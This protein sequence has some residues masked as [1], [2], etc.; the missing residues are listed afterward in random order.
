MA[1][2]ADE[3]NRELRSILDA[4]ASP[5]G[6][7]PEAYRDAL[8]APRF[9]PGIPGLPS[10][11][12]LRHADETL[13]WIEQNPENPR[14]PEILRDLS[15]EAGLQPPANRAPNP[16]ENAGSNP[17]LPAAPVIE[18][19]PEPSLALTER[20]KALLILIERRKAQ[21]ALI[22]VAPISAAPKPSPRVTSS[23][24]S[25]W[26]VSP[27]EPNQQGVPAVITALHALYD[28]G[29]PGKEHRETVL[30]AVNGWLENHGSR[31]IKIAT[32]YRALHEIRS[33]P[34][35]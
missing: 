21:L 20:R 6:Y 34:R 17:P 14:V 22:S 23:P 33:A 11:H 12:F 13:R 5:G 10:P 16:V 9:G 18:A 19:S 1:D 8:R 3:L 7:S 2:D 32:L 31:T 25:P 15:I 29:N 35:Q 27:S 28:N 24:T 4:F 26:A 30:E